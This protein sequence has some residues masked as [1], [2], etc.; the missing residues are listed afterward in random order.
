MMKRGSIYVWSTA[1]F[2]VTTILAAYSAFYYYGQ[3]Q[4][5]RDNYDKLSKDM[6]GLTMYVSMKLDY[7]NGTVRWFNGTR[8]PLNSTVLTATKLSVLTEYQVSSLGSYVTALDGV[9]GDAHHYWG[10]SYW[11]TTKKSWIMGPVGSDAWALHDGDLYSW[12][13]TYF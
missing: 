5:Y 3:A 9:N 6:T 2:V 1:L 11:D 10:W 12:T 13:Y 7:G 8:V 4:T